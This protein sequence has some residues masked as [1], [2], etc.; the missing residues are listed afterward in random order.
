MLLTCKCLNVSIAIAGAEI[1]AADYDGLAIT[2]VERQDPFFSSI[3]SRMLW[4]MVTL[5]AKS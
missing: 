1:G 5:N 2:D 3:V 4:L